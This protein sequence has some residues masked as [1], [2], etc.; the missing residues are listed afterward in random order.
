MT[1]DASSHESLVELAADASNDRELFPMIKL[2]VL[3]EQCCVNI[4][5][6]IQKPHK[7]KKKF[8]GNTKRSLHEF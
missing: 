4:V 1:T 8:P 7:S 2:A 3:C 6:V 5:I